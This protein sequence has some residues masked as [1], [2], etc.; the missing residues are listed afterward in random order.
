MTQVRRL[1]LHQFVRPKSVFKTIV[2]ECGDCS[3]CTPNEENKNCSRYC[4]INVVEFEV[5]ES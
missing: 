1:C 4:P 3:K 5:K 2:P